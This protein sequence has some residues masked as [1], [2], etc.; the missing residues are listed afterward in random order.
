MPKF[1]RT[2]AF[3]CIAS[4]LAFALAACSNSNA[5]S[6]GSN[7]SG[8]SSAASGSTSQANASSSEGQSTTREDVEA[9]LNKACESTFTNLSFATKTESTAMGTAPNGQITS[10]SATTTMKGQLDRSASKPKMHMS[11]KTQSS[12]DIKATEY[13]MYIDSEGLIV[14]QNGQLYKDAMTDA[15]L[16]SYDASVTSAIS[17]EEIK[18]VL[19][20]ASSFKM[21]EESG[22]TTVTIT[23][24]KE[25]LSEANMVDMSSLPKGTEIATMVVAYDINANNQFEAV[26]IMSSTNGN[27]TYRVQQTYEYS[28]Y[29]T[30]ELPAWPDMGEYAALTSGIMT[31]ANGNMY[32]VGE[33]GQLYYVTSIGDDGTV[34]FNASA[35]N[36]TMEVY[37]E[38]VAT[39]MA[40][41]AAAAPSFYAT[42]AEAESAYYETI[43]EADTPTEQPANPNASGSAAAAESGSAAA[44]E[45]GS[46]ASSNPGAGEEEQGR[47][48]ITADDGTIHFLDEPGSQ[49]FDNGDGTRYFIDA[50][51]NFYFLAD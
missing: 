25:K 51:G 7:T 24:D 23:L 18:A 45:S 21:K 16:N 33:D 44:A 11:T 34:V 10:Q 17:A 20:M 36:E 38:E 6:S 9:V 15:V 13:D 39:E 1:I 37:Y 12:N 28:D 19:D 14:T 8:S 27:P 31:D 46:A 4:L 32:M 3:I 40:A 30:T 50:D 49:L 43:S 22:K 26:R 35:A 42:L 2:I 47:A 5:A 29:D 48:Y 41:E